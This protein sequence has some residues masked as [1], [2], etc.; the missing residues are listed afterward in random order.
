ML[1]VNAWRQFGCRVIKFGLLAI[2]TEFLQDVIRYDCKYFYSTKCIINITL[3]QLLY[4]LSQQ[5]RL[6][7]LN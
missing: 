5:K 7:K 4:N 3:F 6:N 2:C 1:K